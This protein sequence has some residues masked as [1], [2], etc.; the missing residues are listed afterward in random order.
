MKLQHIVYCFIIVIL[1][2]V[3]LAQRDIQ[4]IDNAHERICATLPSPHPDCS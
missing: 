3:L 1:F 4:S 2:N